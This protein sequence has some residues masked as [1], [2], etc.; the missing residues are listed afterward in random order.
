MSTTYNY[1]FIEGDH[2]SNIDAFFEI[3][4]YY[5]Y[6]QSNGTL[7]SAGH[8]RKDI[9]SDEN[10][11]MCVNQGWTIIDDAPLDIVALWGLK[12]RQN[13]LKQ[14]SAIFKT[15]IIT[16]YTF[17]IRSLCEFFIFNNGKLD[18]GYIVDDWNIIQDVGNYLPVEL[19]LEEK[20]IIRDW[21]VFTVLEAVTGLKSI[22]TKNIIEKKYYRKNEL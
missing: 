22:C 14:A 4:G 7:I 21:D 18:R 9:G 12:D 2:I 11:Q 19:Q 10:F 17:D 3:F 8:E 16:V 1:I 5:S 15:R 6:E 13:R 20:R